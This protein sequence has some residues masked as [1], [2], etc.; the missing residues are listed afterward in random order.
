M[1]LVGDMLA[2]HLT[3]DC[4]GSVAAVK[5][6]PSMV[7]RATR[8]PGVGRGG[9]AWNADRLAN[10][11]VDYPRAL[12]ALR[13]A[14]DVFHVVDHSYSQ[15][16]HAVPPGRAVVTCHDLDT[17][18]S[19]LEPEREPRSW[20]FRRM[21]RR[22]LEGLRGAAHVACVSEAVRDE[23]LGF[24]LLPPERVSVVPNGV[25][26]VFSHEAA[27]EADRA[28][29]A[30][31][32]AAGGPE[33]LHVGSTIPRKRIEHLLEVFARIRE[34][35][36]GARLV[37]VGGPLTE[38][39]A[40]Q[41]LALGVHGAIAE[42]PFVDAAVLAAVYRRASLVLLPSAAEGFGLPLAEALACGARVLASD[43]PVLREVGGPHAVFCPVGDAEAWTAAARALLEH[44]DPPAARAARTA[45]AARFRWDAYA[46][47]MSRIYHDVAARCPR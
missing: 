36:P 37:R 8:L 17:F 22:I 27:P 4:A 35:H 31:L 44:A 3:R 34:A 32:G 12:R 9:A 16:V 38:A 40:R 2:S 47:A 39:Q 20:A 21:T 18:R 46:L 11:F 25:S 13:G 26:T 28:A 14:V 45:H 42:L 24:G 7:R 30:L 10:R 33:V 43:L 29:A 41:A 15:L 5:V 1:D 23:L 6:R 19:V